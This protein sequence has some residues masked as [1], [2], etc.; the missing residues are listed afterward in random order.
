MFMGSFRRSLAAERLFLSHLTP[1]Y[2]M[3]I[4]IQSSHVK[5]SDRLVKFAKM[6]VEHLTEFYKDAISATIFFKLENEKDGLNKHV[7]IRLHTPKHD[8]FA[9]TRS[10]RF[11]KAI[12]LSNIA[13]R[14]QLRKLKKGR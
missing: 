9:K 2:S 11:E 4:I 1:F 6:Q 13:V 7:E 8:V 3:E 10:N 14:R 12:R 5:P